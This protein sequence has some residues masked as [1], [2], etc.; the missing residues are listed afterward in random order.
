MIVPVRKT[1]VIAA[2]TAIAEG[3]A[4]ED[5]K[6]NDTEVEA[7]EIAV[8]ILAKKMMTMTVV[9]GVTPVIANPT[10]GIRG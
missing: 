3:I 6:R 7:E 8:N 10:G 4:G 1:T 5:A 9:R 2:M